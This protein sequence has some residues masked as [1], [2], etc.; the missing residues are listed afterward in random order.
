MKVLGI[1]A[2]P[3]FHGNT[4]LLLAEFLRGAADRGAEVKTIRLNNMKI[5]PC[6][7]CD[8]C[9]AKGICKIK[10][11]MQDIYQEL[12]QADVIAIASPVQFMGPTAPLKAMIDRAQSLWAKKYVL[13]IPPLNP[14]K[15]RRGFFISVAAT[16][17][18][19]MFDPSIAIIRTWCRVIDIEY[20]GELTFSGI[21]EKA[22]VLKHAEAMKQAY[23]AGEKFALLDTSKENIP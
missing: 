2:S 5:S 19:N 14:V 6:Q 13:K 23:E 3:R 11:E 17:I 10:D 20:S 22:A 16:R 12:E 15:K 9:L 8:A 7:H 4:E 18:K 1:S 21:D